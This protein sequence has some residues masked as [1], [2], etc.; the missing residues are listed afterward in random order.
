MYSYQILIRILRYPQRRI[1]IVVYWCLI[2]S[3]AIFRL[4]IGIYRVR[5]IILD[6][7]DYVRLVGR[8]HIGFFIS[9]ALAEI[10]SSYF[11]LRKLFS[12]R[13]G[14]REV[15]MR[16]GLFKYL[17]RSTEIRITL[18]ALIG[19][20][21]SVTYSFQTTAQTATSPWGEV[22]RFVVVLQGL[23]PVIM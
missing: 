3:A 21:R 15:T 5:G 13:N 16:Q 14:S 4:F 8:L 1:F 10:L 2:G 6:T 19:V 23:F 18:L 7:T 9:I 22:D 11:L 17:M 20:S 12:A